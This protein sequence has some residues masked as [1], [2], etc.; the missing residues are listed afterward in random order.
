[1]TMAVRRLG[2]VVAVLIAVLPALAGAA[3][4]TAMPGW[5]A[6]WTAAQQQPDPGAGNWS[7][8]GFGD[9]TIRQVVRVSAGGPALRIRL[10]N[11]YGRAATAVT[12]ATVA[13][14]AAGGSLRPESVRP[15]TVGLAPSF[16]I[17]P[18]AE[19]ATDPVA[20]ATTAGDSVTVSMYFA[21]PTGPAT[22]HAQASATTFRAAGDHAADADATGFTAVSRSWYYLAGVDVVRAAAHPDVTVAFGDSITDGYGSTA[23]RNRRYPDELAELLTG[24]GRSRPVLNAGISGNRVTVDSPLL[25]DSA[26]ARFG[27]DALRQPGVGSVVVLE[28]INDIGLGGGIGPDGRRSA[29]VSAGRLIDGHRNLIRQARAAGIRIVGATMLPFAGSAYYTADKEHVRTA[30]NTWIRTSSE[31]DAVVDLDA[32]MAAPTDRTRLRPAFDSGDHLHPS[33]AGYRALAAAVTDSGL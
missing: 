11:R 13:H 31:Y 10:S 6:V 1:M 5:S 19:I 27:R 25:G 2:M 20:L 23:D 8:S 32:A 7:A 24:A 28:G 33:D 21:R 18:G 22:H 16:D 9:E 29:T 12:H 30:V 4:S 3:A 26:V 17:P 15:L 14:G